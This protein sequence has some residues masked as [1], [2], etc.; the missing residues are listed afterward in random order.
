MAMN[1]LLLVQVVRFLQ[2]RHNYDNVYLLGHIFT[3]L[4]ML[5]KLWILSSYIIDTLL[6]WHNYTS[7]ELYTQFP[8]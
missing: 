3:T 7:V 6:F 2:V 1:S 5:A 4:H 8:R